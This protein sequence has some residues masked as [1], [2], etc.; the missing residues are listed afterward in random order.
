MPDALSGLTAVGTEAE[1]EMICDRL[2][3]EGIHAIYQ[4]TIGGPEWGSSGA[5]AVL[6]DAKD[7]DRARAV[8]ASEEGTFSDEELGR[9]SEQ[10]GRE[11][12]E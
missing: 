8:L 7:L 1:A 3:T 12:D 6:V 2:L 9:L 10:A 11:A 4:R 5:R